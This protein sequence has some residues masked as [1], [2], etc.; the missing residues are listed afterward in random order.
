MKRIVLKSPVYYRAGGQVT[1]FAPGRSYEVP[2]EYA[3]GFLRELID[4]IEDVPA[5]EVPKAASRRRTR[6]GK[7]EAE[8]A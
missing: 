8:N 6:K 2:D 3:Q 4:R 7:A 1:F 5:T